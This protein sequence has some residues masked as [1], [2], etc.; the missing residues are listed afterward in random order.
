M[1]RTKRTPYNPYRRVT[2]LTEL[3][4]L[5]ELHRHTVVKRIKEYGQVDLHDFFDVVYFLIWHR[6]TYGSPVPPFERTP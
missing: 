5:L 3:G 4:E 2:S 6:E 1:P